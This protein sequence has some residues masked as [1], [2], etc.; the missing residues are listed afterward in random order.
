MFEGC[1]LHCCGVYWLCHLSSAAV[2]MVSSL[3]RAE[4]IIGEGEDTDWQ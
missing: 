2:S 3:Q 4:L 1:Y